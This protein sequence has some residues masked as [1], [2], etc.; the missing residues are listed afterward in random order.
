[1]AAA[2][3][4]PLLPP[5]V[6]LCKQQA[7]SLLPSC[8]PATLLRSTWAFALNRMGLASGDDK[9]NRWAV[10]VGQ[11]AVVGASVQP[12]VKVTHPEM[13]STCCSL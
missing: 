9:Y 10:Q 7:A 5:H 3:C 13:C 4:L 12:R 6:P 1:M 8:H 2:C 11:S